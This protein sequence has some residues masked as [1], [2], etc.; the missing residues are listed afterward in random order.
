MKKTRNILLFLAATLLFLAVVW[1]T[2]K[3]VDVVDIWS[4]LTV[5]NL[6]LNISFG[7][8]FFLSFGFIMQVGFRQQYQLRINRID[9][10]TLPIMMHLFTYIMPIK[11]GMLFQTFFSRYKYKLDLTKG[12][13]LGIMVFL[14]SLLTTVFFGCALAFWLDLQSNALLLTLASMGFGLISLPVLLRFLPK[15][16]KHADGLFNRLI[17][18]LIN[19]RS[20]LSE[21]IKNRPLLLGLLLTTLLSVLIQSVWFY[22]TAKMLGISTELAPVILIVLV[23]RILLLIRLLPGNLGIQELIIGIVF[24]A[25]GFSMEEGLIIALTTRAVSVLLA[26]MIGLPALYSNLRHFNSGSLSALIRKGN[27]NDELGMKN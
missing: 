3:E 10:L 7:L 21:Q 6:L 1:F 15:E 19:V 16:K 25:A 17:G 18:F 11:G 4:R 14:I 9:V 2:F 20:Q 27:I 12:F 23:L 24:N 8:A 5:T 26:A 22:Q 13:S